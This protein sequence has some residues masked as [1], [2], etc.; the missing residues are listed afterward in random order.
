MSNNNSKLKSLLIGDFIQSVYWDGSVNSVT[1]EA[2]IDNDINKEKITL[3]FATQLEIKIDVHLKDNLYRLEAGEDLKP[4]FY[5]QLAI[6]DITRDGTPEILLAIGDGATEL[7]LYVWKFD[8]KTYLST[9]KGKYINPFKSLNIIEG[10]EHIVIYP[11]G[12][13]NVPFGSQELF[14]SYIWDGINLKEIKNSPE[15]DN[16]I[17]GFELGFVQ[18]RNFKCFLTGSFTC[19]KEITPNQ[20]GVFLAYEYDNENIYKIIEN[21]VKP[22]LADY[23]LEPIIAGEKKFNYDFMCKICKLIQESKYFI[24]DITGLNFNVGFELGIASGL[25]KDT[26]IIADEASKESSDLK[27]TEAIRYKSD[28]LEDFKKNLYQMISNIIKL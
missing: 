8:R 4:R 21:Y 28:N 23:K 16:I 5:C 18:F 22:I 12:R 10:Q 19:N 3:G 14:V 1:T 20:N 26:I 9:P 7:F 15:M 6:K 27:R 2:D 13:I 11:S 24:A 25:G 17:L